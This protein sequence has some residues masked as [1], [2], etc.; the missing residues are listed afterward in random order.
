MNDDIKSLIL[1]ACV[2]HPNA[3]IPWPHQ[4]LHD[5]HDEL[6]RQEKRITE[7][8]AEVARLRKELEARDAKE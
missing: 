6:V 1:H 4:L 5:A 7:L 8:E 2:G 3:I